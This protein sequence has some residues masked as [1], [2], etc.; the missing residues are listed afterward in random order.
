M[1]KPDNEGTNEYLR[2]TVDNRRLKYVLNILQQPQKARACGTSNDRRPV[3]PPPVIQLK[4]FDITKDEK[5]VTMSYESSF[6]LYTSLEVAR[7]IANGRMHSPAHHPDLTGVTV[8]SADHLERPNGPSAYFIFPDLSLS[9]EGVTHIISTTFDFADYDRAMDVLTDVVRPRWVD[10]SLARNRLANARQYSPDP[11]LFMADVVACCADL[12]EGDAEAIAGGICAMGGMYTTK[13]TSQVTHIVALSTE[14][15][16]CR[17]VLKEQ[18]KIKI[19]LPHWFDDCLKLG[20]KIDEQPYL[21]PDPDILKPQTKIPLAVLQQPQQGN[22]AGALHPHPAEGSDPAAAARKGQKVFKNRAVMLSNDLGIG[23]RLRG[24]LEDLIRAGGGRIS[25]SVAD[26]DLYICKYREGADYRSASRGGRQ[27]GNLAWLY[28]LITT[29]TWTSPLRRLLHYPIARGGVPG[30]EGFKISLSNYTGEARTYLENLIIAAGAEYTKTLKQE[31]THLITAHMMSEK[32]AAAKDWGV[33]IINHL[34]LEESYARWKLQT[35]SNSR[36]VHFPRRTNLGE[37]VGQTQIDRE[38][39]E[40]MFFPPATDNKEVGKTTGAGTPKPLESNKSNE[41]RTPK[42]PRL[43]ATGKENMTPATTSGRK[44]KEVAAAKLHQLTPDIALYE[45]ERKRVG[46]VV[47]GGRVKAED[48]VEPSR[49]RSI[50]EVNETKAVEEAVSHE[51]KKARTGLPPVEMHLLISGYTKWLDHPRLE[52]ADRA[53]LRSLGIQVTADP[54]KATHLA[55]PHI[56]R[57]LKFVTAMAYAPVVVSTAFIDAC[58]AQDRLLDTADFVLQDKENEKKLGFSLKQSRKLAQENGNRLL[59][60]RVIYCMEN[61]AGG[62]EAYEAIIK[63]N[64]GQCMTW[65]NRKGTMVPSRRADSDAESE[66]ESQH[67]VYLLSADGAGNEKLWDRFRQMVEHSRRTPRI[68]TTDWLIES[69][70]SQKI[71]PAD[72]YAVGSGRNR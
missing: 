19:V 50:H 69:A 39:L 64:G 9:L 56:V 59:R 38:V 10:A 26:C 11:R 45:R 3:D 15:A 24:S 12:P 37:V 57:T 16:K 14:P 29:D 18:L 1:Q 5:D 54:S 58:L 51:V 23:P 17:T 70:L 68:V 43:A 7:P 48:R 55:A 53:K 41:L 60:T 22:V 35:V 32:C 2:D 63:A 31:N 42:A 52:D 33:E 6:M 21:L 27:V 25:D 30:F 47:Y 44:S 66:D 36:Y 72:E 40:Q 34:W 49:K 4:V 71:L 13:L 8:A 28:Y 46:G 20:R 61:V 65:R 62:V 67:D